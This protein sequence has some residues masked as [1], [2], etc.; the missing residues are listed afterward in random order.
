MVTT[1]KGEKRASRQCWD[2]MKRRLVCDRMLPHCRKCEKAGRQCSG[3]DDAKPLQWVKTGMVSSRK[4]KKDNGAPKVYVATPAPCQGRPMS[5]REGVESE[6]EIYE[7]LYQ[8]DYICEPVDYKDALAWFLSDQEGL[9]EDGL[10]E[11]HVSSLKMTAIANEAAR[12]FK[13]WGRARIEEVVRN[14]SNE[15]AARILRSE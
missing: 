12:V 4:R 9:A 6:Q 7:C 5:R 15:E 8:E 11:Q 2:C 10:P 13:T 3:F 1:E 14:G